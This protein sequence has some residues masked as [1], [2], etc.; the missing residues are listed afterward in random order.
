M[1]MNEQL[2]LLMF[3]FISSMTSID[4]DELSPFI[5]FARISVRQK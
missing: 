2:L 3:S 1:K 5:T 4:Y